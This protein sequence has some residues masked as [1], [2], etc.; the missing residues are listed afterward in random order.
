[1]LITPTDEQQ[2]EIDKV[3][4]WYRSGNTRPFW[5]AGA[6]GTGKSSCLPVIIDQLGIEGKYEICA[7]SNKAVG[8]L[9]QKGFEGA[10]T[11]AKIARQARVSGP[12]AERLDNVLFQYVKGMTIKKTNDSR[13][14][15]KKEV[16]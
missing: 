2:A 14:I 4:D 6:A 9:R 5:F 1:M 7:P 3:L 10:T 11:V 13:E 15:F 8:V 12:Q 16:V